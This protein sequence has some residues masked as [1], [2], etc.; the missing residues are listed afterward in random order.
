MNYLRLSRAHLY[1]GCFFA[2]LLLAFTIS[3]AWQLFGFHKT[4]KDGSYTPPRIV[5]VFSEVHEHQRLADSGSDPSGSFRIFSLAMAVGLTFTAF[6]GFVLAL[7]R[8]RQKWR[9]WAC[10]AGGTLLPVILLYGGAGGGAPDADSSSDSSSSEEVEWAIALHGGAGT[11]S[12]TMDSAE[13]QGYLDALE[14]ALNLGRTVLDSGGT[15]LDAVERVIRQLE[16][17]P[18]FNAGKGAV[19]THEGTHEL[20]ASIM[21]GRDLACGAVTAVTTVKNPI[22]LAR[23]VMEQTEHVLLAADGAERFADEWDVERVGNEYFFTQKRWEALQHKRKETDSDGHR[24]TVGVAAL[25]RHGD[26]AAGTSTGGLTG[27]RH[28][29]V[30]DSPIV[31]AGTYA[32]N[33]TCAV[34][35]TGRGEEFIRRGV[36]RSVAARMEYQG[37]SL[38]L[39]AERTIGEL[40]PGDGGIVAVSQNGSIAMPY[41]T[42]GMFRAAADSRGRFDVAIWEQPEP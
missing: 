34:S 9:V 1:L 16:D 33:G 39:A 27:K 35:A 29:R 6:L 28:G 18:R 14:K 41:N 25:D 11:P 19:F 38:D 21:S 2:P 7:K 13:K 4:P 36:A 12:R 20:D 26:L 40:R 17:D 32:K 31:G 42:D 5:E 24:G 15:S 37:L 8:I 30:G 3:G 22:S 23:L 10:L